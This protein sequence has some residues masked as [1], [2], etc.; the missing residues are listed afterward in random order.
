VWSRKNFKSTQEK[1]KPTTV[2]RRLR[3]GVRLSEIKQAAEEQC[4]QP[5]TMTE[6]CMHKAKQRKCSSSVAPEQS[7]FM[8]PVLSQVRNAAL[9]DV[10]NFARL[11]AFLLV[12]QSLFQRLAKYCC[13]KQ[14]SNFTSHLK[15]ECSYL[16]ISMTFRLYSLQNYT[17]QSIGKFT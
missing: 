16:A 5:M 11:P 2:S 15:C 6:S 12:L 3:T 8:Q 14:T 13:T 9:N 4:L 10:R 17:H 7:F 1:I